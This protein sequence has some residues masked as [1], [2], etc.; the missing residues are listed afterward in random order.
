MAQASRAD[1]RET[2]HGAAR[3][4]WHHT[5]ADKLLGLLAASL[6]EGEGDGDDP[7]FGDGGALSRFRLTVPL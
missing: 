7:L 3:K 2:L 1:A 6:T 4:G 5:V